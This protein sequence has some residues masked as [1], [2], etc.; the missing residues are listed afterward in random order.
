MSGSCPVGHSKPQVW[1]T[2]RSP[3]GW[4]DGHHVR[5]VGKSH[6][7]RESRVGLVLLGPPC[8]YTFATFR[9]R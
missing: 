5:M 3:V 4:A 7:I 9:E 6:H 1:A 8:T 2:I